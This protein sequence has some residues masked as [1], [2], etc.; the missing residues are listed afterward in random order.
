[1]KMM[2]RCSPD[3]VDVINDCGRTPMQNLKA[4][5]WRFFADEKEQGRNDLKQTPSYWKSQEQQALLQCALEE[6]DRRRS[7]RRSVAKIILDRQLDNND[8]V[9]LVIEYL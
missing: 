6:T 4:S 7:M 1:M 2:L 9:P 5:E 3:A 8:L